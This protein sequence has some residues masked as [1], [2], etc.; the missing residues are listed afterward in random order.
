LSDGQNRAV[1]QT[2]EEPLLDLYACKKNLLHIGINEKKHSTV[3]IDI[4]HVI[5]WDLT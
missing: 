4:Y 5:Q 1:K 2:F 3:C